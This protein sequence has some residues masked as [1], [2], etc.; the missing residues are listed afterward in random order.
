VVTS[1]DVWL[2]FE[3]GAGLS[4]TPPTRPERHLDHR[5]GGRHGLTW[6][7]HRDLLIDGCLAETRLTSTTSRQQRR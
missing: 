5:Q 6:T 2:C 7:D 1:S 4:M 3:D